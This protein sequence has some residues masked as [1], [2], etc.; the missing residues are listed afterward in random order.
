MWSLALFLQ[1]L[2]I[3][4]GRE[5]SLI[6]TN[7]ERLSDLF[8]LSLVCK[9]FHPISRAV[10]F[11]NAF[12]RNTGRAG[13]FLS[14]ITKSTEHADSQHLPPPRVTALT[15]TQETKTGNPLIL[16]RI[17]A[18]ADPASLCLGSGFFR[19]GSDAHLPL[20]DALYNLRNLTSLTFGDFD[21]DTVSSDWISHHLS[22][23]FH[24]LQRLELRHVRWNASWFEFSK[25]NRF[26]QEYARPRFQLQHLGVTFPKVDSQY[27]SWGYPGENWLT[28]LMESTVESNSLRSLSLGSLEEVVPDE[29]VSLLE[30]VSPSLT[31]L[32]I[33]GYR[34]PDMLGDLTAA[35]SV[36][37][38]SLTLGGD[39]TTSSSRAPTPT[40]PVVGGRAD[41]TL[42][43]LAARSIL[44]SRPSLRYLEIQN[45]DLFERLQVAEALLD[46]LLPSLQHVVLVGISQ[47]LPEV[48]RLGKLCSRAGITLRV[49]RAL[50]N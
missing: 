8:S 36:H 47:M 17:L 4:F 34:G 12:L 25:H 43:T 18:A 37:L 38:L 35:A 5:L 15:W 49:K 22:S 44:I 39:C 6:T 42:D 46:G 45:S 27:S 28:W 7:R 24:S 1:C 14:S 48:K 41:V 16:A 19:R 50:V 21:L 3:I 9:S 31:N 13:L 33:T 30:R 2:D 32:V 40:A 20:V 29:V 11:G 23:T 10:L 26:Y